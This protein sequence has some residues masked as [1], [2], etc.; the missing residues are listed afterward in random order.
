[1]REDLV[2]TRTRAK[3]AKRI[4]RCP[5]RD[6]VLFE[7]V[8]QRADVIFVGVRDEDSCDAP[9]KGLERAEVR[10]NDVDAEA[11][12]VEGDAAIDQEHP[13]ALLEGKAVHADLAEAPER[14]D[15][16]ATARFASH[17]GRL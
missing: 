3:Q 8:G 12:M 4:R 1:M 7:E 9:A 16:Q 6:I 17:P 10:V 11:A 14:T 5:D 2:L 15:A 13:A